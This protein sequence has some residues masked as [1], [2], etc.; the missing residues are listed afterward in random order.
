MSN[1]QDPADLRAWWLV[2]LGCGGVGISNIVEQRLCTVDHKLLCLSQAA[3]LRI[4][5]VAGANALC[6]DSSRYLWFQSAYQLF[7]SKPFVELFGFRIFGPERSKG[8]S[9]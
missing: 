9:V 6:H 3:E 7:P 8:V 2:Y 5:E 1:Y 4:V